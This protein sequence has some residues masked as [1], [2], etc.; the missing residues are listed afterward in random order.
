M[1]KILVPIQKSVV[2]KSGKTLLI[3]GIAST[4]AI[5]RHEEIMSKEAIEKMAEQVNNGGIPIRVEH[6]DLVFTDI[7]VWK[8]AHMDENGIMEVEGEVNLE[9]S[10]GKDL[11]V[12]LRD[13]KELFLSVG[14]LVKNA[15][16]E[17]SKELGK[18]IK[19]YVDIFLQEISVV[20]NPANLGTSLSLA[21]SVDWNATKKGDFSL[22]E[23]AESIISIHKQMKPMD[24]ESFAKARFGA[25]EEDSEFAK[26]K[27]KRRSTMMKSKDDSIK[28]AV[29]RQF[30]LEDR[31]EKG[32]SSKM[33]DKKKWKE[34]KKSVDEFMKDAYDWEEES[35]SP[36]SE[37]LTAQDMKTL[38]KLVQIMSDV[39]L[40]SDNDYPTPL[41]DEN[42][43]MGLSQEMYIVLPTG[44][45]VMPHHNLDYTVNEE[46][47]LYQLKVAIEGQMYFTPKEYACVI[48]HLYRHLK[49]L[50]LISNTS[51]MKKQ[52]NK[53]D[54]GTPVE[55]VEVTPVVE[56]PTAEVTPETPVE[57]PEAPAVET[58]DAP[59]APEEP[60]VDPVA[61][62]PEVTEPEVET[63][64]DEDPEVPSAPEE[65]TKGLATKQELNSLAELV[66]ELAKSVQALNGKIDASTVA[67]S[68]EDLQKGMVDIVGL[69]KE[70]Q[71]SQAT[72]K[73]LARYELVEKALANS[74]DKADPTKTAEEQMAKGVDF[75]TAY[76]QA[77][78]G[79]QSA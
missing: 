41:Q 29:Q 50:S 3:K 59:D 1:F 75:K 78:Y 66:G 55:D 7:G 48:D 6:Q 49:E 47:V 46:L 22:T 18:D 19:K 2:S 17:F 65:V 4:P 79:E 23:E 71:T 26:A 38:T 36:V 34:M 32:C 63:P 74:H 11:Q 68:V 8:K 21:K 25:F 40:P 60:A 61:P 58:P 67:K 73:S 42:Y 20:K 52:V 62:T 33:G 37:G 51:S 77:H 27:M 15:V 64:K 16:Y 35:C 9:L 72:R 10:L 44:F 28:D 53:S 13:G 12:L 31:A 57:T 24:A 30:E 54:A 45:W 39:E 69:I 56:T 43:W 70:V 76:K 14:G 5:D